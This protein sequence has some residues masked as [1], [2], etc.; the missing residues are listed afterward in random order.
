M[1]WNVLVLM[2]GLASCEN[3]NETAYSSL[4]L[5]DVMTYCPLL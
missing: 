2:Q 5:T 1:T 3:N 4:N